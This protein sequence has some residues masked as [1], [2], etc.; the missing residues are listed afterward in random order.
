MYRSS[1]AIKKH[2]AAE[3]LEREFD[4]VAKSLQ[5]NR[6]RAALARLCAIRMQ[7]AIQGRWGQISNSAVVT[8]NN[9]I[10]KLSNAIRDKSGIFWKEEGEEQTQ[11]SVPQS[12]ELRQ[13]YPNPFN[14]T[15]RIAFNLPEAS[16]ITLD[17]HNVLGQRVKTLLNEALDA[18]SHEVEWNSTDKS[19]HQVASGVSFYRLSTG[20]FTSTKKM[21][22]MK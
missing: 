13:N 12:S 7:L 18:G 9:L 5:N 21:V 10:G 19:G 17:I 6:S 3:I 15:T 4:G 8:L 20:G 16:T 11:A 22:L 2:I 14:P 1:G